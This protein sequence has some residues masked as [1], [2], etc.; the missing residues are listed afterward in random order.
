MDKQEVTRLLMLAASNFPS[1]Q[2]KDL[3]PTAVLWE[4]MLSDLPYQQAEMAL[5]RVLS[6]AKFFPTVA[7]IREAVVSNNN[8]GQLNHVE[9]WE[10]AQRAVR[11]YGTYR[12]AEALA[13]LS[14]ETRKVIKGIGWKSFCG[15]EDAEILRGQFRM[16][17]ETMQSRSNEEAKLPQGLREMISVIGDK[18]KKMI[19]G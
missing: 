18:D 8:A 2:E 16:M 3:R 14:P 5:I 11:N 12:E 19:G 9:A 6:S 15:S 7:D 17:F 4:K 13:S 1:L 10:E